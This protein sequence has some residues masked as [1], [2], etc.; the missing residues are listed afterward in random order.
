MSER[1][2]LLYLWLLLK[3]S[4][5]STSGTGNFPLVYAEF[6]PRGWAGERQFAES[7][8]IGQITPGPTGLWVI[9]FGYLTDGLRGAL[10]AVIAIVVPP[11]LVVP[12]AALYRR[13]DHHPAVEGFVRGL[14]LAVT[15]IFVVVMLRLLVST[16]LTARDLAV[17]ALAFAAGVTGRA[18]VIVILLAAAVVGIVLR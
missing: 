5:F 12:I 4:L 18:P 10:F 2:P 8:A 13:I 11:V 9:S 6:V 1:Q 14:S 17:A 3:A 15:G 7:L 16:G